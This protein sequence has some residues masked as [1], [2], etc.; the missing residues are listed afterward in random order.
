VLDAN[1]LIRAVLGQRVRRILEVH[2]DK[3]SF[4]IPEVAYAEA[5]EQLAALVAK[6]G[7]DPSKALIALRA[8]SALATMVGEEFYGDFEGEARR[9]LGARDPE[10]WPIPAAALALG[11][12]SEPKIL[13]SSGVASRPG[14]RR[15]STFFLRISLARTQVLGGVS[16][17]QLGAASA[18]RSEQVSEQLA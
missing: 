7:G 15:A 2:A 10:D 1:I 3:I 16:A 11:C 12:P 14:R 5:E 13:T 8:M 6:R 18:E 4:F 9:R 17:P